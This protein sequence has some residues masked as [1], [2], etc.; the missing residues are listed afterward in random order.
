MGEKDLIHGRYA[1]LLQ[2]LQQR[3]AWSRIDNRKPLSIP[4]DRG[5]PMADVEDGER[6]R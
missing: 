6:A 2:E 1:L 5:I 4:Y 3:R